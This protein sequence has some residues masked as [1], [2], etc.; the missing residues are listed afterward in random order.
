MEIARETV[1]AARRILDHKIL[2]PKFGWKKKIKKL[3]T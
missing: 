3:K 1:T 2:A